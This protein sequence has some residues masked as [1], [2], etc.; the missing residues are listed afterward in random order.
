MVRKSMYQDIQKLKKK[1]LSKREV[2]RC[3]QL[4]R[5]TVRKYYQMS[6]D[7]YRRY[8]QEHKL[9]NRVLD[10][11]RQDILEI[12]ANNGYVPINMSCPD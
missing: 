3:L 5:K 2:A 10:L 11:Y 8:S 9:R 12:H 6:E 7:E 4:D 1:R